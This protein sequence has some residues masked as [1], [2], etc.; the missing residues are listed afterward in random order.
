MQGYLKLY[1]GLLSSY[2]PIYCVLN[3]EILF[4][5]NEKGGYVRGKIHL[6]VYKI[7]SDN[8]KKT[9]T[10]DNG[11]QTLHFKAETLSSVVLWTNKLKQAKRKFM[12]RILNRTSSPQKISEGRS[13]RGYQESKGSDATD[14][15]NKELWTRVSEVWNVQARLTQAMNELLIHTTH[16][17]QFAKTAE[18]IEDLSNNLKVR[19]KITKLIISDVLRGI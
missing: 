6:G 8:N 11:L 7:K 19:E 3:N 12:D 18:E 2:K 10:L 14:H 16:D 4:L 13:E 1:Q 17:S 9:L 15:E 5:F